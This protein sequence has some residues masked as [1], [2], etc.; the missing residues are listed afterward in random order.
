MERVPY[1]LYKCRVSL[2]KDPK[3]MLGLQKNSG[4]SAILSLKGSRKRLLFSPGAEA[5]DPTEM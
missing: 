3:D 4:I 5:L 1:S 2:W